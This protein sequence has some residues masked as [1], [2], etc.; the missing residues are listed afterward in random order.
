MPDEFK[1]NYFIHFDRQILIF[2]KAGSFNYSLCFIG[3]ASFAAAS[4][5]WNLAF[6]FFRRCNEGTDGRSGIDA[7][8]PKKCNGAMQRKRPF[9][10]WFC[11]TFVSLLSQFCEMNVCRRI[12]TQTRVS[13]WE[14]LMAQSLDLSAV[15]LSSL[16]LLTFPFSRWRP[17][18]AFCGSMVLY[19]RALGRGTSASSFRSPWLLAP[20]KRQK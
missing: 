9:P 14:W 18:L 16:Q 20:P 11:S 17:I 19:C 13:S 7:P 15:H 2:E 10:V 12:V 8:A 6:I 4:Y 3:P 1:S 5:F